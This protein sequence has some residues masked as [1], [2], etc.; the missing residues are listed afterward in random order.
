MNPSGCM[1]QAHSKQAPY[2]TATCALRKAI[3]AMISSLLVTAAAAQSAPTTK[4]AEQPDL[5]AAI[6]AHLRAGNEQAAIATAQAALDAAPDNP[7]I[8]AEFVDL[9]LTL[10]RDWFAR[11]RWTECRAATSAILTLEPD[12]RGANQLRAAIDQALASADDALREIDRLLMYE[13]YDGAS[14]RIDELASLRPDWDARLS[15]RRLA[16]WIGAADDHYLAENFAEAFALYERALVRLDSEDDDLRRRWALSLALYLSETSDAQVLSVEAADRIVTRARRLCAN[17]APDVHNA[18]E[19]FLALRLHRVDDAGR[20]FA[21]ALGTSWRLPPADQRGVVLSRLQQQVIAAMR[22]QR[23]AAKPQR[24]R[25]SPAANSTGAWTSRETPHFDVFARDER[26]ADL[27]AYAAEFHLPRLAEWLAVDLPPTWRPR[28]E[29][30][31]FPSFDELHAT[32]GVDDGAR[33]VTHARRQGD[34][35]LARSV[36]L[37][38][39]DDWLLSSTLPRELTHI[40]L[41]GASDLPPLPL[42]LEQGLAAQVEPPARRLQLRRALSPSAPRPDALLAVTSIPVDSVL[43]YAQAD[44]L[45][46][47]LCERNASAGY[48]P[49]ERMTRQPPTPDDWWRKLGWSTQAE[50]LVAWSDWY[51]R[52]AQ[53]ARVPL[54]VSAPPSARDKSP[55]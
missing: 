36:Q 30:R 18:I 13:L 7:G 5:R 45:V 21:A 19:G 17:L 51:A 35:V 24:R 2:S 40:L 3:V 26:L 20:A 32:T 11:H 8:R 27:I 47:F 10:A 33:A 22:T 9:H 16:A 6:I 48:D 50:A 12:H 43:F 1:N 4:V 37:A 55:N 25:A 28:C 49:I 31:V 54:V 38:Q 44:A 42:A 23:Q 15:D 52:A 39:T 14:T 53:P 41:A 29:L 46:T 34:R